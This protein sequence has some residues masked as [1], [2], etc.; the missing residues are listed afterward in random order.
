M[1]ATIVVSPRRVRHDTVGRQRRTIRTGCSRITGRQETRSPCRGK[2]V[3]GTASTAVF[4]YLALMPPKNGND[5]KVPERGSWHNG[6]PGCPRYD[7]IN[8]IAIFARAFRQYLSRA[9]GN[10]E[11]RAY[12]EERGGVSVITYS[13]DDEIEESE[14]DSRRLGIRQL[15]VCDRM[16]NCS[17]ARR[18]SWAESNREPASSW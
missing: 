10:I 2:Q 11:R 8:V 4:D 1:A 17:L 3:G 16:Q 12:A 9:G 15:R 6:A 18:E 14:D 5:A 13:V 7:A